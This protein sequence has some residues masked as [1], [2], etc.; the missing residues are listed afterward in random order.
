MRLAWLALFLSSSLLLATDPTAL[1]VL[2]PAPD[3]V[4]T[5]PGGQKQALNKYRGKVVA[6]EMLYTTCPHCQNA[7]RVFSKLYAEYGSRGFEP[8]GVAF[9]EATDT[10]VSDFVKVTGATYPIGYASREDV[11]RFLGFS[12]MERFV[13]PQIVWIDRSGN[14]RSE[15]PPLGDEKTLQEP[16]WR[17]MIE[18]LLKD[19]ATSAVRHTTAAK[20]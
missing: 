1:P 2:R 20:R 16:Y 15:T 6:L 11:L 9:N 5:Y 4:I 17:E 14:I 10:K 3:F 13:V 12:E 8:V 18:T 19:H 7:A